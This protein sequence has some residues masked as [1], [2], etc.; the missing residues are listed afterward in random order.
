MDQAKIARWC[1]ALLLPE[2]TD[3]VRSSLRELADYFGI[4]VAEAQCACETA[5]ADSKREWESAPRQG[6]DQILDFYDRTRSYIFEHVWWHAVDEGVGAA[7]VEILDYAARCGARH[8]LDFGSG[9]GANAIL[10][11]RQGL[12]VTLA[13]V[14]R[15]MLEFARWRLERR[16]LKATYIYLRQ[17]DLPR[18]HFDFA[19]A[20]DVFEHLVNPAAEM[21][22]LS[23]SLRP[24]GVMVFNC[25]PGR[26][27]QRPMHIMPNMRPIFRELR[28]SGLREIGP[29]AKPLRDLGYYA[30]RRGGQWRLADLG[31]GV[32]DSLRYGPAA[33]A[34]RSLLKVFL[35]RR[36]AAR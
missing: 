28:H 20:V 14:S 22:R 18:G 23:A 29:G 33:E 31:W 16:G 30:V 7:N 35:A 32:Y 21:R 3:L 15:T 2:E 25:R 5:L 4:S 26:D 36:D 24:G 13:D 34:G 27:P 17:Q 1:Q 12:N 11:A 8:Y 10:F 19:T 6:P 9:V